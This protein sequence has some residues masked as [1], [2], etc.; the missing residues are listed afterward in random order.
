MEEELKKWYKEIK[1]VWRD[2]SPYVYIYIYIC[3]VVGMKMWAWWIII[4]EAL[5]FMEWCE[6]IRNDKFHWI[7]V[8]MVI[9][10]VIWSCMIWY[11]W[12]KGGDD[13]YFGNLRKVS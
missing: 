8:I 2:Y 6:N 12:Y 10:N 4:L 9:W 3:M 11:V 13:N 7:D 1:V 5:M